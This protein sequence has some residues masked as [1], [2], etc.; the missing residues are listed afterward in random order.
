VLLGF[1]ACS[2]TD[3]ASGLALLQLAL[4]SPKLRKRSN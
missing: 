4:G 3:I 2:E 1:A